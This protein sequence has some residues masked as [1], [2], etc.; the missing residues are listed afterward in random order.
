M[1]RKIFEEYVIKNRCILHLF[2]LFVLNK[3]LCYNKPH[4]KRGI[5]MNELY[6]EKIKSS[7]PGMWYGKECG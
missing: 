5:N 1:E 3:P 2:L 7:Y 4:Q 6:E